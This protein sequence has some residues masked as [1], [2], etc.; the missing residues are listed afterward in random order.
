MAGKVFMR[1]DMAAF[2][3]GIVRWK[4]GFA[5]GAMTEVVITVNSAARATA[6]STTSTRSVFLVRHVA[7]DAAKTRE[8][9]AGDTTGNGEST[10]FH[11]SRNLWRQGR[12][13]REQ[14]GS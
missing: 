12:R 14:K 6:E 1:L 3:C 13:E 7:T 11:K 2:K 9:D 5:T 10:V 8:V 4:F